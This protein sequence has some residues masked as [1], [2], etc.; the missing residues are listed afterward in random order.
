MKCAEVRIHLAAYR[1]SDWSAEEQQAVSEHLAACGACRRWEAEARS[2]GE[3]L[4]EL[5]TIVP[6]ASL[7]ASVFAAIRREELAVATRAAEAAPAAP[8]PPKPVVPEKTLPPP[9]APVVLPIPAG[10]TRPARAAVTTIGRIGEV[11]ASRRAP[12]IVLGPRAAIATIAALFLIMFTARVLPLNG[13]ARIVSPSAIGSHIVPPPS[14]PADA[15]YPTATSAFANKDEVFYIGQAPSGKEMLIGYNRI[16]FQSQ[17]LFTQPTANTLTLVALSDQMLVWL[18][19]DGPSWTLFAAPLTNDMLAPLTSAPI[20]LA[21]SGQAFGNSTLA[22]FMT[23]SATNLSAVF[24]AI[25]THG[26]MILERVDLVAA[27]AGQPVYQPVYSFITEALAGHAI[28]QPYVDGQTVYWVDKSIAADGSTLGVIWQ[29]VGQQAATQ[30]TTNGSAFYP[31][32]AQGHLVWF[33]ALPTPDANDAVAAPVSGT[34]MYRDS[35]GATPQAITSTSAPIATAN[36]WRGP[37]YLMWRDSQ[38]ANAQ[39]YRVDIHD[40][41]S[42]PVQ[43]PAT[44]TALGLSPTTVTWVTPPAN[45]AAGASSTI[46]YNEIS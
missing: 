35:A 39:T 30:V 1:R 34:L 22:R 40:H 20:T 3:R 13:A 44:Y 41:G 38:D 11:A 42:N 9:P 15:H 46:W 19:S 23:L 28:M 6:P 17:Y 12:R 32:A 10:A 14:I 43:L 5:P 2:V 26:A 36:V 31:V 29:Q 16:S 21:Y 8:V 4:R 25:D 24:T 27:N 7:R 45:G 18:S 37:G 33:Q